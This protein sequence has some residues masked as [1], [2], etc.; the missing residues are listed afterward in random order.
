MLTTY[1]SEITAPSPNGE[2]FCRVRLK[3]TIQKY[4]GYLLVCRFLSQ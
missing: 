1:S 4:Y 2:A 3:P